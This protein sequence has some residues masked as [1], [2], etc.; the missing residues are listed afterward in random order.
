[1]MATTMGCVPWYQ[2]AP[3]IVTL[4]HGAIIPCQRS[5]HVPDGHDHTEL[6]ETFVHLASVRGWMG[7]RGSSCS[8]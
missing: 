6:C 2:M 1:M 5:L 7:V 3:D 8:T 4:T